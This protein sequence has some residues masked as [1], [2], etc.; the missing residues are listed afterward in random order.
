MAATRRNMPMHK[1]RRYD[2]YGDAPHAAPAA[3][4]EDGDDEATKGLGFG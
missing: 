2:L 3:A 4:G 1:H